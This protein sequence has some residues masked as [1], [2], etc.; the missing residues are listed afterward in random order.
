[1]TIW[2]TFHSPFGPEVLRLRRENRLLAEGPRLR[3]V[4]SLDDKNGA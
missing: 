4:I 3:D 2:T 1:M